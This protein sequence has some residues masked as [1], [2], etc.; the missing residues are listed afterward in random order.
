MIVLT[1]IIAIVI[2]YGILMVSLV[3]V[4]TTQ[5]NDAFGDGS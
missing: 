5:K 2:I 3:M 1:I 4:Y